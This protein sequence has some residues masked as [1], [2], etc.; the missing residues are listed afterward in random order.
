M[1]D[2]VI[3]IDA[4]ELVVDADMHAVRSLLCNLADEHVAIA[5][6]TQNLD[7]FAP[8][9]PNKPNLTDQTHNIYRKI[10]VDTHISSRQ[11]RFF[12]V[13]TNMR[14]TKTHYNYY[15]TDLNG[16]DWNLRPDIGCNVEPNASIA[17]VYSDWP[18]APTIEH[19][20]PWRA[21]YRLNKK[22]EYY[23]L[24]DELGIER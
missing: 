17:S 15:G 5:N 21:L 4:D 12:R 13:L 22:H 14:V 24:R 10:D 11:S 3:V 19:R 6:I 16:V 1:R 9:E 20:D 23:A 7:P 2:W 8:V 18:E